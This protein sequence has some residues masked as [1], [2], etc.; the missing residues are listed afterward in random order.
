MVFGNNVSSFTRGRLVKLHAAR[1][2][3]CCVW[4]RYEVAKG[5]TKP[6]EV[7]QNHERS[8]ELAGCRRT[9]CRRTI[10]YPHR[11]K[12]GWKSGKIVIARRDGKS[13][14]RKNIYL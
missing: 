7:A 8:H 12:N 1:A 2:L 14:I 13:T 3:H 9:V 4:Y 11:A 10:G 6:R 5:R